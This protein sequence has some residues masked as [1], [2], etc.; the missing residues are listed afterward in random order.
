MKRC[1]GDVV[2]VSDLR[3]DYY[4]DCYVNPKMKKFSNKHAKITGIVK[5]NTRYRIDIDNEH[6]VWTDGMLDD[7]ITN[8]KGV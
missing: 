1:V 5:D 2:R 6:W 3:Y 8:K 4:E 7:V